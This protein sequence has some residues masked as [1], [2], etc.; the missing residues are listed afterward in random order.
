M[1]MNFS[2]IGVRTLE[3]IALEAHFSLEC[4]HR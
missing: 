4:N 2:V 3:D 1:G